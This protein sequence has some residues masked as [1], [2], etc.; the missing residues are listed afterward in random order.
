MEHS[1]QLFGM[2]KNARIIYVEKAVILKP[3][4]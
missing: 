1:Q 3:D 4:K 2:Q